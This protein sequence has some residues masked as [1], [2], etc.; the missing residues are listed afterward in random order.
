MNSS[1]LTLASASSVSSAAS[2]AILNTPPFA[3]V[4]AAVSFN[5]RRVAAVP[6]V[7]LR[8]VR[9]SVPRRFTASATFV[10]ASAL[11]CSSAWVS[12]WGR[13]S[14]FEAVSIFTGSRVP[15]GSKS[16]MVSPPCPLAYWLWVSEARPFLALVEVD[17]CSWAGSGRR[18][19]LTKLLE[20]FVFSLQRFERLALGEG[21]KQEGEHAF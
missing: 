9:R 16:R 7:L 2:R 10:K 18:L 5:A 6:M 13:Y 8:K 1:P 4:A 17:F 11:A 12:G 20:A 15:S 3:P 21:P 14:P 19:A